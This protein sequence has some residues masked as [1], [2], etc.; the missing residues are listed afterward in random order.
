MDMGREQTIHEPATVG[1]DVGLGDDEVEVGEELN[2]LQKDP[3]P[4]GAI[5]LRRKAAI[6]IVVVSQRKQANKL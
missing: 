4:V 2:H 6:V 5:H 3:V 1:R